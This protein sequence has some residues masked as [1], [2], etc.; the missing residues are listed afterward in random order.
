MAGM[1]MW[2][3]MEWLRSGKP[4][5]LGA[6]S[7][8]IAGLATITPA[9]GF[10]GPNSA[11]AIGLLA[12]ICCYYAVSLKNRLGFDDSLDVVGIHGLGGLLGTVCLGIFASKTV[13]PAGAD[14]LL[15][16]N[17][18]FLFTELFGILVV[19][20]YAFVISWILLK[21][22]NATMGLRMVREHEVIGLDQAEHS[23]SAYNS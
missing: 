5:T 17:A 13:N 22:I 19:G 23:E 3:L 15:A 1:A 9:A 8:A 6:A 4:T 10:V 16:G 20:T 7:G 12:G 11:I 2:S 14:G 21:L 18:G